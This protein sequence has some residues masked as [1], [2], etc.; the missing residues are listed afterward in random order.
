MTVR[1]VPNYLRVRIRYGAAIAM[2]LLAWLLASLPMVKDFERTLYDW[3][4]RLAVSN[5]EPLDDIVIVGIDDE[6]LDRLEP[7]GERWPWPRFIHGIILNYCDS[8][9]VVAVDVLFPEHQWPMWPSDPGDQALIDDA[10]KNGEVYLAAHFSSEGLSDS[11]EPAGL[12]DLA[13]KRDEGEFQDLMSFNGVLAPFPELLAAVARGVPALGHRA[14]CVPG[15]C[16]EWL[17]LASRDWL[18]VG[19]RVAHGAVVFLA[20]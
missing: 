4:V 10:R 12:K 16:V 18:E 8:A 20:G 17:D 1:T 19:F 15:A 11:P 3:R 14:W 13:M 9:K 7:V 5:D 6:S 2:L